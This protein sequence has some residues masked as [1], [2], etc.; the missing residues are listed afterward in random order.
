MPPDLTE[1]WRSFLG[2][3]D[4][5]V[6][7]DTPLHCCGGFV[8]TTLYAMPRTTADND[9]LL[10]V[11]SAAQRAL[12]PLAGQGSPL[13]KKHGVYLDIVAVATHPDS[14]ET[15]LTDMYPGAFQHLQL[16]ALDPYDL[17]LSK[18]TR[19]ADRDRSDVEC[20]GTAV[21]L[22]VTVLRDRYQREMRP[23]RE[24][25]RTRRPHARAVD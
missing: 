22:N 23:V 8:L 20:L 2:H 5:L 17:A 25:A 18:L 9:V 3:L 6:E 12:S 21:P 14:Y 11:G 16:L 7:Q 13:H 15:R 1:P 24:R 4:N 10:I 19:N